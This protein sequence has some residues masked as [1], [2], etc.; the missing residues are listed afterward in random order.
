MSDAWGTLTVPVQANGAA[1]GRVAAA[2]TNGSGPPPFSDAGKTPEEG[3]L[4][5]GLAAGSDP[6]LVRFY[7]RCATWSGFAVTAIGYITLIGWFTGIWVLTSINPGWTAM[8]V[9]TALGLIAAGGALSLNGVRHGERCWA[10]WMSRMCAAVILAIVTVTMAEYILDADLGIDQALVVEPS[11]AIGTT[12]PGRMA[13]M[14]VLM[15]GL[16]GM[17]LYPMTLMQRRW[18][19]VSSALA[20]PATVTSMVMVLGYIF[21]AAEL[22]TVSGRFTAVAATTAIASL[23]L[24]CGILSANLPIGPPRSLANPHLGGMM[25]RRMLPVAIL[26]PTITVWLRLVAQNRDLFES[27]EFGAASVAVVMMISIGAILVW[28]AGVLDRLDGARHRGDV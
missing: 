12:H 1:S 18:L 5:E 21:G 11:N 27:I 17:S 9:N 3:L 6:G 4:Q 26:L 23:L 2:A 13:P 22:Y 24:G 10:R 7:W 25:L 20:L 14:T 8:K 15:F 16:F 19:V 28:Y